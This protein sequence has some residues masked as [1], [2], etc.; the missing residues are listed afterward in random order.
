MGISADDE[1]EDE[2]IADEDASE[3]L[4]DEDEDML[5]TTVELGLGISDSFSELVETFS[6]VGAEVTE[7]AVVDVEVMIAEVEWTA[8]APFVE[9]SLVLEDEEVPKHFCSKILLSLHID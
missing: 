3:A 8:I 5:W 9:T 7:E 2:C 4:A 6:Y 1:G